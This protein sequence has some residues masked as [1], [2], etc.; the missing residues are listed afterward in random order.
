MLLA[1]LL[2]A[3]ASKTPSSD[4]SETGWDRGPS[5]YSLD[6]V[7]RWNHVQVKGTHNSTH[8]EPE[9]VV[10]P[11]HRYSHATLT[12]QLE[13]QGVR[14]FELDL[15]R[16]AEGE[17]V[18]FHLPGIDEETTCRLFEDC[19]REIKSW[20]D[21]HGWHLPLLVW[22]EPKDDL[23]SA[24][25]ELSTLEGH[26]LE[27]DEVIRSVWAEERL[28]TPDDL[29]AD[30]AT[31]PDALAAS[32]WPTLGELRGQI[33]FA[34]IDTGDHRTAYLDGAPALEGRALFVDSSDTSEAFAAMIKDGDDA[35]IT[36]WVLEGWLVTANGSMADHE[37][38]AAAASDAGRMAAGVHALATDRAAEGDDYWLDLAPRCNPVSA[39]DVCVDAEVEQL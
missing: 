27:M 11:S 25:P 18:V 26:L 30:H 29:R 22:I 7:L 33:A 13:V 36:E 23:D 4:T 9:T 34:M 35:Q 37:A 24:V 28:F 16:T 14:Q 8:L 20:S 38:D 5:P 6:D 10:H 2:L 1:F 19:L 32:G 39:P 12:D 17:L 21:N 31:L 3:C 15:H